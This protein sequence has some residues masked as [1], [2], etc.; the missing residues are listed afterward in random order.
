[1]MSFAS[2]GLAFVAGVLSLLS[3]CVLP[4]IPIVLGSAA[5][6]HRLAPAALAAGL[7]FSFTVI[8]LFVA[9]IG[10]SAGLDS[11]VFRMF[12]AVLLVGVGVVLIVPSL[13]EQL[14]IAGGPASGWVQQWFGS[15][16]PSGISGQ[17]CVGLLLGAVW[18]P[19]VGPTLGA[20]SLLASQGKQL[21]EV[22]LVMAVF[23]IGAALPLLLFGMLSREAV[24][25][26][27]ARAMNA[28]RGL[29]Q[30]LG[31]LLLMVGIAIST[32]FD[33]HIEA[34]LVAASPEWLMR[35]TTSY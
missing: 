25:R 5:A 26:W 22:G 31:A 35:M 13:Q 6:E 11:E 18:S 24:M 7:A 1:M 33:K 29:R 23:G 17:F 2:L 14:A 34:A 8:G 3:P 12:A 28:G 32:G 30:G 16:T 19:C 27:R 21:G 15:F 20:A 9:T 4:L 10:F